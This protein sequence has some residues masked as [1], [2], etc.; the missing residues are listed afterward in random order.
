MDTSADSTAS[1]ASQR[2]G[3][4]RDP[5]LLPP[6]GLSGSSTRTPASS[7]TDEYSVSFSFDFTPPRGMIST[8][9]QPVSPGQYSFSGAGPQRPVRTGFRGSRALPSNPENTTS[10]EIRPP[11]IIPDRI[12]RRVLENAII[13]I[14]AD[15]IRG[16]GPVLAPSGSNGFHGSDITRSIEEY[17]IL[18]GGELPTEEQLI[19]YMTAQREMT[20]NMEAYCNENKHV[21]ATP[22]LKDP[23]LYTCEASGRA[24]AMCQ[25][26]ILVGCR[27]YKLLP[28]KHCFHA[29]GKECL[30]GQ[31]IKDW[32][33][34]SNKCPCCNQE[35]QLATNND[36]NNKRKTVPS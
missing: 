35:V 9:N 14:I 30:G 20:E 25:E 29:E 22:G 5:I 26:D 17:R 23:V 16:I 10:N 2:T 24:C 3:T 27:V 31:T 1:T 15:S 4:R 32:L 33:R 12:R 13:S 18:S 6:S 36:R 8:L 21:D 7:N 11:P 19:D 34:H 28:C